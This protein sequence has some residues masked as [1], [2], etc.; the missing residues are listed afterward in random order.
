M[1]FIRTSSPEDSRA[2]D[3]GLSWTRPPRV[4]FESTRGPAS[5]EPN[6]GTGERLLRGGWCLSSARSV[7]E[8]EE[9]KDDDDDDQDQPDRLPREDPLLLFILSGVLAQAS[10]ILRRGSTFSPLGALPSES[11]GGGITFPLVSV[12]RMP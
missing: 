9:E 3:Q 1:V 12:Q 5:V 8:E 4:V 7:A 2:E 11:V 10:F 6:P